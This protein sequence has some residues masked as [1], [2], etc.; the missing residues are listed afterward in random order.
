MAGEELHANSLEF[1][2]FHTR[3]QFFGLRRNDDRRIDFNRSCTWTDDATFIS[4][5]D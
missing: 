3:A 4:I 2:V 1:D 5:S